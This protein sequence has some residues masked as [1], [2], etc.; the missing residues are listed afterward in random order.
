[1]T[2]GAPQGLGEVTLALKKISK[3]ADLVSKSPPRILIN[4]ETSA[5]F[6]TLPLPADGG[7]KAS[8]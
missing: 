7:R 4:F 5:N 2:W 1:V 3:K 8:Q 6:E